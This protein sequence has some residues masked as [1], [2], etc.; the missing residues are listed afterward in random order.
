MEAMNFSLP[1]VGWNIIGVKEI[2]KNDYN[3][4]LIKFGNI[5][6]AIREVNVLINNKKK[7]SLIS[8]K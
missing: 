1:L 7:Y 4:K 8:K 3:G 2:I 6:K 5:K